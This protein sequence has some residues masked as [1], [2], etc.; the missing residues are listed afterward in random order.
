MFTFGLIFAAIWTLVSQREIFLS[1]NSL[2][3]S[4][5]VVFVFHICVQVSAFASTLF[6][7]KQ[8][9]ATR[10]ST[11]LS[12]NYRSH[13]ANFVTPSVIGPALKLK[14]FAIRYSPGHALRYLIQERVFYFF[15]SAIVG[16][17]ATL[18]AGGESMDQNLYQVL[19]WSFG[20]CAVLSLLFGA[21]LPYV[22]KPIEERLP[23]RIFNFTDR[24]PNC[25]EA[26]TTDGVQIVASSTLIITA[27]GAGTALTF[28]FV[29][30]PSDP[31]LF[32]LA[33]MVATLI[34]LVPLPIPAVAT[35]ELGSIGFL[36]LLGAPASM[37][38]IASSIYILGVV[39]GPI[40]GIVY[41]VLILVRRSDSHKAVGGA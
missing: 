21:V 39:T 34:A 12:L 27:L 30:W 25:K 29:L 3:L 38:A 36:V 13:M 23:R 37:A 4:L 24:T 33:R 11:Q 1:I 26:V 6:F 31:T 2:G 17:I 16:L 20:G 14:R 18:V 19:I 32:L 8:G 9:F 28:G 41:E 40:V 15:W 35:T 5:F 10:F 7:R 22:F